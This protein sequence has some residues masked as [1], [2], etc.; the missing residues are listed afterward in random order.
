MS[1]FGPV[2]L[3]A[4]LPQVG[5]AVS[6]HTV[7]LHLGCLRSSCERLAMLLGSCSLAALATTA[8]QSPHLALALN[9]LHAETANTLYSWTLVLVKT[10]CCHKQ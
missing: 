1:G 9:A 5:C 6:G 2:F 10:P 3:C 7:L 4:I 8:S